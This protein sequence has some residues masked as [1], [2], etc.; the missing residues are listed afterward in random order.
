MLNL[1]IIIIFVNFL[2]AKQS[3]YFLKI[4]GVVKHHD[5]GYFQ[6]ALN[7][8]ACKDVGYRE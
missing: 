3:V 1:S 4:D 2:A 5:K 8:R 6:A 7:L